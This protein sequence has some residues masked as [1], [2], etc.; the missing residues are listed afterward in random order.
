MRF[1]A[2]PSD[3]PHRFGFGGETPLPHRRSTRRG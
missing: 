1:I 2:I 3:T